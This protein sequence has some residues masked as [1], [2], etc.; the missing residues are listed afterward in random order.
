M[1]LALAISIGLAAIAACDGS[2]REKVGSSDVDASVLM[3]IPPP[4]CD[5]PAVAADS[6]ACTGGGQPGADCL[7]CHHQG[8]GAAPY[9][10]AGTLYDAAGARPVGGATIYLQDAAG[11]VATAITR[12]NGN[13]FT[14]DGFAMYPAKAFVSLC[15]DVLEMVGPVDQA[16]GANCN[17]SGCHTAGF[18][19]HVP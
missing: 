4:K 3:T 5:A 11:N 19:V 18:R 8:G 2:L 9:T 14:A 6:G 7:M 15:P 10:F 17:T 12:P 13:F 1:R 16:T